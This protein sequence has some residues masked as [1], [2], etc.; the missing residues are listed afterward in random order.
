MTNFAIYKK[1]FRFTLMRILTGLIGLALIIGLPAIVFAV[2]GKLEDTA[3]IAACLGGFIVGCIAAGLISHF[4]SYIFRAGQ[5]AVAAKAAAGQD[6]PEDC[7]SEGKSIVKQRFGTV[8]V[9]FAIEKIINAIVSQL[10]SGVSKLTD[11]I[12]S[13]SDSDAVKTIGAVINIVISAML[14]FMCACCMGWVFINPDVNAWR[15]ACD[16]A[17]LYFKNWKDLL[18][19]TGRILL[20]GLLS[21]VIIGGALFGVC[22]LTLNKAQFMTEMTTELSQ[23]IQEVKL[24]EATQE[25]STD[26]TVD[27]DEQKALD[28]ISSLTPSEWAMI[29]EGLIALIL[30]GI[31]NSSLIDPFVMIGVM[32]RYIKAGLAN[33]PKRELDEKLSGLSKSYKKAIESSNA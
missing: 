28:A 4:I 27:E 13:D 1:T 24:E 18:K 11:K 6:L 14:K 23:F 12:S 3:R 33:P 10:T 15:C 31:L 32:Q 19:N 25:A 21:L 22:H 29:F 9:F 20:I 17:I 8:A 7:Y 2:T 30:W 26:G 5:I 16:G